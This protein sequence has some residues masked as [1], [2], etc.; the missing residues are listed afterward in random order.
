ML[1][2]KREFSG[3][4]EIQPVRVHC[5]RSLDPTAGTGFDRTKNTKHANGN[6]AKSVDGKMRPPL[7]KIEPNVLTRLRKR[8]LRKLSTEKK[9]LK[10]RLKPSL[11]HPSQRSKPAKD[12]NLRKVNVGRSSL[13]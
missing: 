13:P 6:G 8:A 12:L 7:K 11:K 10:P 9:L 1:R 4:L 5:H 2:L 3:V